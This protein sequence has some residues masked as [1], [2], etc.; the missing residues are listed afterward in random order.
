MKALVWHGE[1]DIRLDNVA[2][3]SI[4]DPN[5]AIVRITRSAICGTDLHFIRGTMAGMHEGTILGHEAVH[6]RRQQARDHR[7]VRRRQSQRPGRRHV[8]LRRPG[9]HRPRGRTSGRVRPH[10]LGVQHPDPDPGQ[11][12][13]RRCNPAF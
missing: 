2:D 10:P 3:P 11:R 7:P 5:D 12:F 8:L 6:Q 4:Q 13:R 1:G 9:A